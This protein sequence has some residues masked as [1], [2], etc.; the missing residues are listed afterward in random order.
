MKRWARGQTI[1]LLILAIL[2][3]GAGCCLTHPMFQGPT[4]CV[5][6]VV[7]LP[8]L[9]QPKCHQVFGRW[10][11]RPNMWHQIFYHPIQ[12]IPHFQ[13]P[14]N[15]LAVHWMHFRCIGYNHLESSKALPP[16]QG[17]SIPSVRPVHKGCVIH[18]LLHFSLRVTRGLWLGW[19]IL[20]LIMPHSRR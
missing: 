10:L 3:N 9:P 19:F 16:T 11:K 18:K 8:D 4:H 17:N 7:R 20:F 2:F 12:H 13:L 5:A 1:V 15:T 6:H 14:E